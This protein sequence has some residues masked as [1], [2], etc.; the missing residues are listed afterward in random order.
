[1]SFVSFIDAKCRQPLVH[2]IIRKSQKVGIYKNIL[3]DVL[4][5]GKYIKWK[6]EQR[7]IF[8]KKCDHRMIS[9]GTLLMPCSHEVLKVNACY[10]HFTNNC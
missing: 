9:Y 3:I 6:L 5:N 7:Q 10:C 8:T 4:I 1:M 2:S